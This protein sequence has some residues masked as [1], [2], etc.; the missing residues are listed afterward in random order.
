[1]A[2]SVDFIDT[3][4]G[5]PRAGSLPLPRSGTS[6]ESRLAICSALKPCE[7]NVAAFCPAGGSTYQALS[8]VRL[9]GSPSLAA[10]RTIVGLRLCTR[11]RA[12]NKAPTTSKATVLPSTGRSQFFP[13]L[14]RVLGRV[15]IGLNK[16]GGI[17]G[18]AVGEGSWRPTRSTGAE[19]RETPSCW[20][21]NSLAAAVPSMPQTGHSTA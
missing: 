21:S 17:G 8:S 5:L 3:G 15:A 11:L 12:Q 1:M 16:L 10:A 4:M 14:R 7:K 6:E 13:G 19:E 2:A 20:A 18:W 9:W